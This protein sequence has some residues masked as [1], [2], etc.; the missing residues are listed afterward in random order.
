MFLSDI[1]QN[2]I[3]EVNLGV[4]GTNYGLRLREATFATAFDGTGVDVDQVYPRPSEDR[5]YTYPTAQYDHN[6]G[7]AIGGRFVY[8]GDAVPQLRGKF[9]FCDLVRGR[10]F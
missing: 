5:G 6:K 10:V 2:Q 1:G 3:E 8:E 9:V 4:A 7:N